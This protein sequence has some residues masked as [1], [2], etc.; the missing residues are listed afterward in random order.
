MRAVGGRPGR[1]EPG[2]AGEHLVEEPF[3][4][5]RGAGDQPDRAERVDP[6]RVV[7]VRQPLHP[8]P[9]PTP[10]RAGA[11]GDEQLVGGVEDGELGDH[12]AGQRLRVGR[13]GAAAL[14]RPAG[15]A[16]RPT[17][18]EDPGEAAQRQ[19]HRQVRHHRVRVEEAPQR[20]GGHRLQLLQGAGDRRDQR[21]G[22]R[23]RPDGDPD[24]AE[25]R[26]TGAAFPD[27]V[28]VHRRPEPPR[29]GMPVVQPG[30]LLPGGLPDPSPQRGQ[31]PQVLPA[32]GHHLRLLRRARGA[33]PGGHQ[34]RHRGEPEH[35]ADHV[36]VGAAAPAEHHRHRH[37][38]TQHRQ[39]HQRLLPASAGDHRDLRRT[40]HGQLADRDLR[41]GPARWPP[42]DDSGQKAPPCGAR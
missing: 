39:H 29:V 33:A 28:A 21:G 41:R 7:G 23:L 27:P 20:S 42:D 2:A 15:A 8:L 36:G 24:H 1:A 37:R 11:D 9:V 13:S 38:A 31:V 16:R 6:A 12:G 35:P 3:Q 4:L 5:D 10:F 14:R 18:D 32:G 25:V 19:R 40:L 17:P 26:V 34:H 30:P 22:Q